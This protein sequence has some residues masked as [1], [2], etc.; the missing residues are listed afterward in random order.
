[1]P[2]KK[3]PYREGDWFA[4]P[5]PEG[6]YVVGLVARMDRK[7]TILGY[8]F[9][10]R[11][12]QLPTMKDIVHLSTSDVVLVGLCGDL[13]ILE[14]RWIIIGRVEPWNRS[15][16]P[17]PAFA[18]ISVDKKRAWR[19]QYN[20][21]DLTEVVRMRKTRPEEVDHLP[22]DGLYG[23]GAIEIRLSQLLPSSKGISSSSSNSEER[24]LL[25]ADI[26][27]IDIAFD[28]RDTFEDAL[29]E[30]LDVPA[31]TERVLNEF[32]DQIRDLDD[33]PIIYLALSAL[34]LEH[35]VLQPKIKEQALRIITA[36]H[37]LERLEDPT[38]RAVRQQVLEQLQARL[39]ASRTE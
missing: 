12:E 28:V 6:D 2:R 27:D 37:L 1:M 4:V 33:G 5:L 9:C 17:L 21:D 18:L 24:E 7:G 10:P 39:S 16:W 14:G 30:G 34:Q 26:F 36:G 13:G 32:K 29:T 3:L 11:H 35:G 20:E 31:A 15:E 25:E 8:F 19:V 38:D 23:A 22:E